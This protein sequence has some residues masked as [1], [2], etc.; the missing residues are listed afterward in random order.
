MSLGGALWTGGQVADPRPTITAHCP[1]RPGIIAQ[2][3][4]KRETQ[5]NSGG[6]I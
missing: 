3:D 6:N 5:V 4:R 2:P 1:E